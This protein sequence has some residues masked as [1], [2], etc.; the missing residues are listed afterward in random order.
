MYLKPHGTSRSASGADGASVPDAGAPEI[1]TEQM[2]EA[3][4]LA[5]AAIREDLT[6]GDLTLR[7]AVRIV[8]LAARGASSDLSSPISET[9][10]RRLFPSSFYEEMFLKP[11]R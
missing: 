1:L 4:V 8:Y 2:L 11:H 7:E 5:L 10:Y 9:G 6:D 3:G